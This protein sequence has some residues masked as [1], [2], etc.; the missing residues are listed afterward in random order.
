M[1]APSMAA[2]WEL[3][4]QEWAAPVSRSAWGCRG[5]TTA[6]SSPITMTRGPGARPF[7]SPRTPV[8]ARWSRNGIRSCAKV[9]RTSS[10]VRRSLKPSSGW[11]KISWPIRMMAS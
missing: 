10:A 7:R 5:Q 6:S 2:I 4:P 9:L 11:E 3:W 8:M 1:A